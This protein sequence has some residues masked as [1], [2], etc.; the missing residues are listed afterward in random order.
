MNAR[1]VICGG[2]SRYNAQGPIAG[3]RSYFDLV[4]RRA[5]MEG[6]IVSTMRSDSRKRAGRCS[7]GSTAAN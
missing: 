4:F 6:F 1:M 5:R 3:P 2:I 7:S